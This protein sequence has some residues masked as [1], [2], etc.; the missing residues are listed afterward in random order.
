MGGADWWWRSQQHC[1]NDALTKLDFL[2]PPVE[3][4]VH[5]RALARICLTQHSLGSEAGTPMAPDIRP[6]GASFVDGL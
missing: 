4:F 2:L 5:V 6:E 1:A 3:G